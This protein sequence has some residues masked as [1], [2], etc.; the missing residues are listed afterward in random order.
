MPLDEYITNNYT[1]L[2][3]NT[4]YSRDVS[5]FSIGNYDDRDY[6]Q[7]VTNS[8]GDDSISSADQLCS[9]NTVL[10]PDGQYYFK[11]TAWD[12]SNNVKS[13]SML[14]HIKNHSNK[15]DESALNKAI[16]SIFP[17]PNHGKFNLIFSDKTMNDVSISIID[18]LGNVV[19]EKSYNSINN[20]IDISKQPKGIYFLKIKGLQ[21]NK[22]FKV[23]YN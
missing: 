4:I 5:C 22:T 12:A 10:Y 8:N 6:Y 17:N 7:I 21:I 1:T 15:I 23:V 19:S 9:F 18:V 13:D 11:V 16:V 20:M 3:L 14:I 2:C